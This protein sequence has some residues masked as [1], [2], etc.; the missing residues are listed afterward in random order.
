M[1]T[2]KIKA[3]ENTQWENIE[4][5]PSIFNQQRISWKQAVPI[6]PKK[7]KVQAKSRV[8]MHL[9]IKCVSLILL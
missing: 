6:L 5:R 4:Y 9:K 3:Q 1:Q 2:V 8:I 7:V